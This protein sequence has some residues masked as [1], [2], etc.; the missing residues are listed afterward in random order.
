MVP[1]V[2]IQ[3]YTVDLF[4]CLHLMPIN[5]YNVHNQSINLIHHHLFTNRTHIIS[6]LNYN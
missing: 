3:I 1:R 2:N 6:I 5:Y 4:K